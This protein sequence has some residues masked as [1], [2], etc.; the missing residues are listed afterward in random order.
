MWELSARLISSYVDLANKFLYIL[1]RWRLQLIL[2]GINTAFNCTI[3]AHV[4]Y[5]AFQ[6]F[7]SIDCVTFT[8]SSP[9]LS[10]IRIR[11]LLRYLQTTSQIDNITALI[12]EMEKDKSF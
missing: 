6:V 4:V 9:Q 8:I 5:L 1:D 11:P 3:I 12:E 10:Y 2:V 7:P